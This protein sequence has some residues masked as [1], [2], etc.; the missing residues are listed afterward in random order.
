MPDGP[1]KPTAEDGITQKPINERPSGQNT[2]PTQPGTKNGD[3]GPADEP[4]NTATEAEVNPA[5]DGQSPFEGAT[6][7][8]G[9][10]SEPA[11]DGSR[12]S[13]LSDDDQ[14]SIRNLRDAV[15]RAR[16][17]TIDDIENTLTEPEF[18]QMQRAF[19]GK[20]YWQVRQFFG[21]YIEKAVAQDP[22]VNADQNVTRLGRPFRAESDFQAGKFNIDITTDTE[23]SERAHLR[24]GYIDSKENLLTY[25]RLTIPDMIELFGEA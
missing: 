11:A 23:Y 19:D 13:G 7:P 5:A 2:T 21:K 4:A 9:P 24:R 16:D 25:R 10:S 17:G 20:R 8:G 1:R 22:S 14:A 18:E 15:D 6:Q 12:I 3:S